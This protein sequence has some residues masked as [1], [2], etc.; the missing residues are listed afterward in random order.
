MSDST[1]RVIRTV[2]QI[3]VAL[4]VAV[5]VI[6]GVLPPDMAAS[7]AVIAFAAWTAIVARVMNALEDAGLLPRWLKDE[8][9]RQVDQY[10]MDED[11]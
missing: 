7:T 1:R 9:V 5:P 6:L 4:L 8:P 10:R 11:F 2:Y 3:A